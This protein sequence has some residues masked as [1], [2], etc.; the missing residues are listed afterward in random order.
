MLRLVIR[1]TAVLLAIAAVLSIVG[2]FDAYL[3]WDIFSQRIEALLYS[4]FFS[5][6]V[7]AAV[8]IALSFVLGLLEIVEIMRASHES[9]TLPPPRF[10][11]YA[12][13]SLLGVAALIGLLIFLSL[14]NAAVQQ[15]RQSVFRQLAEQQAQRFAPKIARFLPTDLTA[16]TV[17]PE[18]E[19]A[20]DTVRRSDLFWSVVLYLPDPADEDALWYYDG[21]PN[22]GDS[23]PDTLQFERLFVSKR[24]EE[25]VNTALHSENNDLQG[26]IDNQEFVWLEPMQQGGVSAVLYLGG[27]QQA[28]FRDYSFSE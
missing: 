9:R 1:A 25:V 26:F 12:K 24:R 15:H 3:G 4:V 6:L 10:G 5:C 17:T 13:R 14:V 27:N 21:E 11:Y 18:L 2:L 19:Q 20:M 7:L 23:D 8:G 28:D 22:Y 16:P